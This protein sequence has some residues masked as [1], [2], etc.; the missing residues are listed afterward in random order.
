MSNEKA[1]QWREKLAQSRA[2]L[3]RVLDGLTLAQVDASRL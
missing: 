2:E 3:Q 1:Q